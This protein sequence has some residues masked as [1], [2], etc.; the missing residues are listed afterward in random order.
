MNRVLLILC[1]LCIPWVARGQSAYNWTYWFDTDDEHQHAGMAQDDSFTISAVVDGLDEGLHAFNVQVADTAGKYSPPYTRLFFRTK[2]RTVNTLRYW[3]DNDAEHIVSIPLTTGA[4]TIDVSRIEPGVHFIYC[5]AED[6]TGMTTDVVTRCFYRQATAQATQWAYW[7]DDDQ[8]AK[9]TVQLSGEVAMIDVSELTDG[10]HTIHSQLIGQSPSLVASR[11]FIKIPQTENIGSMTCI[12]AIDKKLVAQAEVSASGGVIS[13]Q[14]DVDSLDVGLHHA[15]F[16][17]ITPSGAASTIAER[18]FMRVISNKEM[19]KMKCVYSLDNQQTYAQSGT[20]SADGRFHF[21]LDVSSM[22]DGLHRLAYMM[23]SEEGV[24]TPQKTA[25]FWKTPLGGNGISAYWYWLNDQADGQVH[26]VTL[27]DRQDPFSL[28][29]LLPVESQPIRSS[30]FQFRV[31]EDKPVIYAKN[32]IHLRF[33]DVSGHFTDATKQFVDES[34][35]QEVTDVQEIRES[36]IVNIPEINKI[37][38][39]KFDALTGDSISLK[40]NKSCTIQV[41]NK[42]GN[43]LL[44]SMGDKSVAFNG[45]HLREDGTYYVAIHDVTANNAP[46]LTL[47]YRHMDKYCVLEKKPETIGNFPGSLVVMSLTGNGFDKLIGAVLSK[48]ST[49]I[50]ADSVQSY[51]YS[52]SK[53]YFTLPT[54]EVDNGIYDLTL[55]YNDDGVE[56][57]LKVSE[58]L[59]LV[60]PNA[61]DIELSFSEPSTNSSPYT[62]SVHLKNTG[63]VGYTY[64][65]VNIAFSNIDYISDIYFVNFGAGVSAQSDS[66]GY[67]LLTLTDNLIGK[68]IRGGMFFF[69]IPRIEA[70]E[71]MVMTFRVTSSVNG[72]DM[73]AWT[74]KPLEHDQPVL[75]N[76]SDQRRAYRSLESACHILS[77]GEHVEELTGEFDS[78]QINL[79]GQVAN[80]SV[81]VG[82]AL[83][84]VHNGLGNYVHEEQIKAYNLSDDDA[85]ILRSMHPRVATPGEIIGGDFGEWLDRMMGIQRGATECDHDE[86]GNTQGGNRHHVQTRVPVDPNDIIG[87]V[88]ESGSKGIKD[89]VNNVYYTIQ[90]ENDKEL[91][92]ASAHEVTITDTL[93]ANYFNLASFE[94]KSITIGDKSA[95]L[96]G[97]KNF[98]TTIDMRPEINAIAQV[99]GSFDEQNGIACWH[100][101]SLDPMTMEPTDDE[102]Q[103]ILPVNYNGNGIGEVSFD[104]SLNPGLKHQTEIPNR[105]SIVFDVNEPIMTPTWTNTID[106]I[107][108][109]S[110]VTDI[111]VKNDSTAQVLTDLFDELSGPWRYDVFVQYGEGSAWWKAAE[112]VPADSIAEVRIYDGINHGFYVVLTDSAGNVERKEAIRECTFHDGGVVTNIEESP[113]VKGS[114]ISLNGTQ[115]T[116]KAECRWVQ[117]AT[118]VNMA[119]QAV[120]QTGAFQNGKIID[121]SHLPSGVY[122]VTATGCGEKFSRKII[123]KTE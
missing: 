52:N 120:L 8:D 19:G 7:F 87:Y 13:W 42:N 73:Y 35:K 123:L 99:E 90:F 1:F 16:Q 110:R 89:G 51:G 91:A 25:F 30:Q 63:N 112:N 3:F 84:A 100:I 85:E 22:E 14:M 107:A 20:M 70:G 115:L 5:Q 104:I 12:C 10:I 86:I 24:T 26:K 23:V 6:R 37:A 113:T 31:V 56:E 118:V 88:A 77:F 2:D 55:N 41:F 93:D 121:L 43:E 117:Q 50:T 60:E 65:P 44:C 17:T 68:G 111:V 80:T 71:E 27:Q 21:D 78:S 109:V 46:N 103:G 64:L 69:F 61:K 83:A 67:N 97:D 39:Y 15:V 34:V 101:S 47:S 82:V 76:E 62:V 75:L 95:E 116:V 49:V 66:L 29:T 9:H 33:Y 53:L 36:Q 18:F 57:S 94:P 122:T 54:V 11:M 74:G 102:M 92:T 105:A 79:A 98:I 45:T 28:I 48:G 58:G 81:K 106:K 38:W 96:T 32:D 114:G 108:P 119:G 59:R 72:F 4:T 40:S